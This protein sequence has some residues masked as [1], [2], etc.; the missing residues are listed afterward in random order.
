MLEVLKVWMGDWEDEEVKEER[1]GG[2]GVVTIP[3]RRR[4]LGWREGERERER[5][6]DKNSF[7]DRFGRP[8]SL[9]QVSC[10]Q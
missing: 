4:E 2:G 3:L 7:V 1:R 6:E 5:E 9:Q 8:Q 10:P